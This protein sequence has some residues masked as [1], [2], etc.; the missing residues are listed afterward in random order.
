MPTRVERCMPKAGTMQTGTLA[1]TFGQQVAAKLFDEVRVAQPVCECN[2]GHVVGPAGQ[3]APDE[4]LAFRRQHTYTSW[5]RVTI[6]D[7]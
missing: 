1:L 5:Q 3:E 4:R 2:V 7:K 6:K